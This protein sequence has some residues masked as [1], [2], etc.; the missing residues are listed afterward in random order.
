MCLFVSLLRAYASL[1][2]CVSVAEELDLDAVAAAADDDGD[3]DLNAVAAA[4]DFH[5]TFAHYGITRDSKESWAR[6]LS[7]GV[8][9]LP[10]TWTLRINLGPYVQN[11]I[12]A[13]GPFTFPGSISK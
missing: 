8:W 9:S 12:L 10:R 3:L 6:A 1:C 13:F 2:P 7:D 5:T 11:L 4:E